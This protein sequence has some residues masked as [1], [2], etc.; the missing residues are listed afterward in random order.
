MKNIFVLI[1][2]IV[3]SFQF[4]ADRIF[5]N[6]L[7]PDKK[8]YGYSIIST[9]PTGS[10]VPI[11]MSF[12]G[13]SIWVVDQ[14]GKIYSLNYNSGQII[15]TLNYEYDVCGISYDGYEFYINNKNKN[16]ITR[17]N[18]VSGSIIQNLY[19]GEGRFFE[20]DYFNNSIYIAERNTNSIYIL[21]SQTAQ[22]L[23]VVSNTGFSIDG[24]CFDGEFIW[25]VD[26]TT[27]KIYKISIDGSLINQYKS[28]DK[29]PCSICYYDNTFWIGDKSGKIFRIRIK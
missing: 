25:T 11:D 4:C 12:T 16:L 19:L 7:D 21:D 20:M 18:S 9:I 3:F 13:D 6:P 23:S 14:G 5:D 24:V 17:V 27:S 22:V 1:L 29:Y 26:S 15:R 28:P 2:L 8:D 10:I